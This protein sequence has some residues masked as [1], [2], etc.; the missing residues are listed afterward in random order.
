M[1]IEIKFQIERKERKKSALFPIFKQEHTHA[2]ST[3]MQFIKSR[4]ISF[5]LFFL[6]STKKTTTN[7]THWRELM[8]KTARINC[9]QAIFTLIWNYIYITRI[10]W[11]EIEKNNGAYGVMF[12]WSLCANWN[13][14]IHLKFCFFCESYHKQQ[15][16]QLRMS[17]CLVLSPQTTHDSPFYYRDLIAN[18]YNY[19]HFSPG[20]FSPIK[21]TVFCI[22]IR[23]KKKL[24]FVQIDRTLVGLLKIFDSKAIHT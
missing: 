8:L 21:R 1:N 14:D 5:S 3:H 4:S 18:I 10:Y 7:K 22:R 13:C 2:K 15:A 16:S 24:D 11:R 9:F 6:Y 12:D 20:F 19:K 17:Q 23:N